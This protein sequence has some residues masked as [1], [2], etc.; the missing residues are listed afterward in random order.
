MTAH[1][2]RQGRA[3]SIRAAILVLGVVA[4]LWGGMKLDQ[5]ATSHNA[6]RVEAE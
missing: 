1:Q 3:G 5:W 2:I 4:G 6:A